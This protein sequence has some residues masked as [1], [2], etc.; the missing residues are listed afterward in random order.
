MAAEGDSS[1]IVW[2]MALPVLLTSQSA[3]AAGFPA[4]LP[5]HISNSIACDLDESG[6]LPSAILPV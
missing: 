6:L 5:D 3:I 2:T 4:Q 1:E